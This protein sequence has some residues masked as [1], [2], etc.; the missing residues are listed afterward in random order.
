MLVSLRCQG[1]VIQY[2][3]YLSECRDDFEIMFPVSNSESSNVFSVLK[4]ACVE[5]SQYHKQLIK[6][7]SSGFVYSKMMWG[8]CYVHN[9]VSHYSKFE[10]HKKKKH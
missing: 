3:L 10:V 6:Q 5:L 9:S 2:C 1:S 8:K 7:K 4:S